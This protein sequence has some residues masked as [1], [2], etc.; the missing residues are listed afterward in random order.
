MET[1]RNEAGDTIA[2]MRTGGCQNP[3][4]RRAVKVGRAVHIIPAHTDPRAADVDL[5]LPEYHFATAAEAVEAL[6]LAWETA[7]TAETAEQRDDAYARGVAVKIS[8]GAVSAR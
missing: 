4:C 7:E 2:W 5:A 8:K 6:E 3:R 1:I